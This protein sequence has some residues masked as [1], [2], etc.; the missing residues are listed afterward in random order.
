MLFLSL[1]FRIRA[2]KPYPQSTD[3]AYKTANERTWYRCNCIIMQ[4]NSQ[5][6]VS[7]ATQKDT[8]G[9]TVFKLALTQK[10]LHITYSNNKKTSMVQFKIQNFFHSIFSMYVI[11]KLVFQLLSNQIWM[12][13]QKGFTYDFVLIKS[14]PPNCVPIK[15]SVLRVCS[16]G[17]GT[18]V[19]SLGAWHRN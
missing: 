6:L 3:L 1:P 11:S 18:F 19:S 10:P 4:S 2:V 15:I 14:L 5:F 8:Q 12:Y 7:D 13:I 9:K 16:S 17:P